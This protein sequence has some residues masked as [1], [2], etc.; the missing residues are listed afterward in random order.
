MFLVSFLREEFR[1]RLI[2]SIFVVALIFVFS[3]QIR[4][5]D[6]HVTLA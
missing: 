6:V 4:L 2:I 5:I 3:L 1:P